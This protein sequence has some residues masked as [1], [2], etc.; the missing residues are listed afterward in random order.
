MSKTERLPDT[1]D[2]LLAELRKRYEPTDIPPCRVCGGELS[3]QAFGGG[4]PHRWACDGFKHDA[5]GNPAGLKPGRRCADDHYL[6]SEFVDRRQDG[7]A[8]V[9]ELVERYTELRSLLA[10]GPP[11]C[12]KRLRALDVE[13]LRAMLRE[14]A[15]PEPLVLLDS[16]RE[17]LADC[18]LWLAGASGSKGS[19]TDATAKAVE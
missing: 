15:G 19:T 2:D 6:Q 16:V 11:D 14:L 8:A 10:E 7:D 17:T 4:E 9:V 5:E 1:D 18:L 12:V 3:L 13:L